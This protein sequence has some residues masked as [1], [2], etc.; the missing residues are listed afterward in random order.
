MTPSNMQEAQE[1]VSTLWNEAV[2]YAR[3]EEN[4]ELTVRPQ[5][6]AMQEAIESIAVALSKAEARGRLAGL[7]EGAKV[8]E[9]QLDLPTSIYDLAVPKI[10]QAIRQRQK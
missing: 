7:E 5:P 1:I 6:I 10:A 3:A 9:R 8:A 2:V 4:Q